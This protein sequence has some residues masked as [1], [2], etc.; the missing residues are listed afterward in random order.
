MK[1][2]VFTI[3]LR[4]TH[5]YTNGWAELDEWQP[6]ANAFILKRGER[7]YGDPEKTTD[8][9]SSYT[10]TM[11]VKITKRLPGVSEGD[12]KRALADTFTQGCRCEH[13]CCGHWQVYANSWQV[14]RNKRK[15]Y[16][17]IVNA[18]ANI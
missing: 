5:G 9:G 2:N 7:D 1:D 15:E 11:T 3:D 16:R 4:K 14:R 12:I 10:R 18:S 6:V 13:D 17:V 8:Y